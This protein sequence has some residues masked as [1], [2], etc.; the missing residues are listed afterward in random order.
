MNPGGKNVTKSR[1]N[2]LIERCPNSR[3]INFKDYIKLF[4]DG[5]LKKLLIFIH[6][7]VII[8][9]MLSPVKKCLTGNDPVVKI[10]IFV[11]FHDVCETL[12][13]LSGPVLTHD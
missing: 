5:M 3:S 8:M 11:Y 6:P 1:T 10:L 12:A 7:S 2:K 9:L 13:Y 4:S